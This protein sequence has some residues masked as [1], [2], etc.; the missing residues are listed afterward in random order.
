L[1]CLG[2]SQLTIFTSRMNRASISLSKL[3]YLR[4]CHS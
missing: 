2:T 1:S 3:S 4:A